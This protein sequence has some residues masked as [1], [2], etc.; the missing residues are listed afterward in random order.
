[1][2]HHEV[3]GERLTAL[4]L[5]GGARGTKHTVTGRAKQIDQAEIEWKLGTDD[6]EIERLA[7]SER[8]ELCHGARFDRN[9]VGIVGNA[10][11]S[12]CARDRDVRAA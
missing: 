11:V 4:E 7:S 9:H 3:L 10:G 2:A 6:C 8:L 5:S 12:R 1:M